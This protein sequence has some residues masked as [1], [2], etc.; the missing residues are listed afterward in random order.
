MK[1]LRRAMALIRRAAGGLAGR[2]GT[3]LWIGIISVLLLPQSVMASSTL[4]YPSLADGEW[5]AEF[6][7]VTRVGDLGHR[8]DVS[9]RI[10]FAQRPFDARDW[11]R[12]YSGDVLIK[13]T[14]PP[15]RVCNGESVSYTLEVRNLIPNPEDPRHM[16]AR[17]SMAPPG[18]LLLD[19]KATDPTP[20]DPITSVAVLAPQAGGSNRCT[21]VVR[22]TPGEGHVI[23]LFE[24][25]LTIGPFYG[26][27][28][29][30]YKIV[31]SV[32]SA[33]EQDS[34][35]DGL[36][37]DQERDLGTDLNNPDT[38]ADG[39]ND[40]E[41]VQLGSNPNNPDTDSDGLNDAEEV[42]LG[43]DVSN[44]DTDGDGLNDG[45]EARLGTDA[46]NPDTDGDG[47]SDGREVEDGTNP[48]DP[49]DEASPVPGTLLTPIPTGTTL[50]AEDRIVP[51]GGTV[52]VPIRLENAEDIASIGFN[53][54][55]DPSVVQVTNILKGSL[56][57]PATFTYNADAPGVI[58]FG[59]AAPTG[60][61]GS[62]SVAV[63]A[64]KAIGAGGSK[65]PL[66]LSEPLVTD[67]SGRSLSVRLVHGQITV[68]QRLVGDGNGDGKVSVLDALIA[69][70]MYVK[71]IP[72]DLIM[73]VN[74]DGRVT[75]DDARQILMM[76][77]P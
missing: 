77:T 53:L 22:I 46:T 73:D 72:E 33:D 41:E 19:L 26:Q 34:D 52:R 37:D 14:A 39:L 11:G 67:S 36:T 2:R 48:L 58:R 42:R 62:G 75:P 63:V 15:S 68:E 13:W 47:K 50:I 28:I 12:G 54:S 32:S 31:R 3:I 57:A 66:T 59:F 24:V 40:G 64:F 4:P 9:G 20:F 10:H 61:S 45:E 60:T 18:P 51:P 35:H 1:A 7:S 8:A 23:G 69:L 21:A 17:I 71:S 55:Y 16:I 29:Y 43:T 38:D 49:K 70:K 27:V 30:N 5:C 56:L 65:S 74:G 44:P 76:A 6:V 25:G